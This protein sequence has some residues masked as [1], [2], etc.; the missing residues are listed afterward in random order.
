MKS[1]LQEMSGLPAMSTYESDE[2]SP[3][4]EEIVTHL[5]SR[6]ISLSKYVQGGDAFHE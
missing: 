2:R 4:K 3:F 1:S 5:M 6:T